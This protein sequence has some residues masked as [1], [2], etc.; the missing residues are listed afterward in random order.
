MTLATTSTASDPSVRSA[1]SRLSEEFPEFGPAI[2]PVVRTCREELRGSPVGALPVLAIYRY[3]GSFSP[4]RDS[5]I[6]RER[7]RL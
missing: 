1:I 7:R 2:V 3:R 4:C 6:H 5:Q